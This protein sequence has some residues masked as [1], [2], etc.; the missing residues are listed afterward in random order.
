MTDLLFPA[1]PRTGAIARELY[2]AR[3]RPAA[4]HP[5]G[6]VDPALLADDRAVPRPG[7]AAHRARPLRDPDAA[8][9]GHPAR[10]A[11]RAR[12]RRRPGRDR[13]R[14]R[15]GGCFA[16]QLAPVPRHP[17]AAVARADLRDGL[18]GRRRRCA[19]TPPTRVYDALA[20]R[21]AEP[22]VPAAGAVRAVRHRGAGHHRVAA[23]RPGR[24]RQAR[25]RRLGRPGRPGD[26]HV[27][28][29]RRGRPGL[30]GWADG[31]AGS[32][33]SPARTPAPT[34]VTWP[35]CAQRRAGVHRRRRHLHRPRPP[36]RAHP[37]ADPRPRRRALYER[38]LRGEADAADAETF[39][40][41]M[42]V[43]FARMSARRRPGHAAAPGRGAQP[44]PRGCTPRTAATSAA[45]SRRPPI[46]ARA[47][48]AA[49]RVRQR[50]AAPGGA[51]HPRRVHLQPRAGPA[52]RR[53]PGAVPRRALVVPGLARRRCAGSGR[54]SP[55]P[56]ASTTP[57]A[58]STTPG[59]SAPSRSATTSPAGSTPAS[60]PGSSPSTGCPWTR[61][62]RP[63]PTS[64]TTCPSGSSRALSDASSR[65]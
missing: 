23:R 1:D 31:S 27:P 42:L 10:P 13:R 11:G 52:R 61:P 16:E 30:R 19:R 48:P 58:S 60:W 54:R 62:P 53:L 40:A 35:R 3:P 21:L 41:H 18:R 5:H 2:A 15:S 56:P 49:G 65:S 28:P 29:G 47:R 26:H 6:H 33:S 34:P 45:T 9:P 22:G 25:R 55:R 36:D 37:G 12:R 4:D 17:V 32:A 24:A 46:R 44:Q 20:A 63:S 38:G 8:Q 7:P 14:G 51:L 64:P 50:P 59:R 57:P 43:E 39:R